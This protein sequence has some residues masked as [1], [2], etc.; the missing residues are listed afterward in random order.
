M[1]DWTT[2]RTWQTGDLVTADDLNG[3]VV[4]DR[5]LWLHSRRPAVTLFEFTTSV[6]HQVAPRLC[7]SNP[8]ISI[9]DGDARF[10]PDDRVGNCYVQL[11]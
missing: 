5:M 4:R 2:P 10:A 7:R 9:S 1:T 6:R 11:P 8:P 3:E